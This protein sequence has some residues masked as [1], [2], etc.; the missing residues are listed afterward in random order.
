MTGM[1][2]RRSFNRLILYLLALP[3]IVA[4]TACGGGGTSDEDKPISLTVEHP[5]RSTMKLSWFVRG[6]VLDLNYWFF[7]FV[8]SNDYWVYKDGVFETKNSSS[9]LDAWTKIE[10]LTDSTRYCFDIRLKNSSG[11]L[12]IA[13]QTVC[14]TTQ[15]DNPPSTPQNL[16]ASVISPARINLTWSA[17]T[18]D[19]G[20]RTYGIYR[21]GSFMFTYSIPSVSVSVDPESRHCYQVSAIDRLDK[22]SQLSSEVCAT[23][24]QDLQDPTV[25]TNLYAKYLSDST[26]KYINL[27]WTGSSDD[28]GISYYRVYRN[29]VHIT[30][31]FSP[32]ADHALEIETEYCYHLVAVDVVGHAA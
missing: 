20:V 25:P 7:D 28:G 10:S 17:S 22:E 21:D 26:G 3:L 9:G 30:D 19:Y 24:P 5:S 11:N 6:A 31:E 29:G 13:S 14:A 27:T 1:L 12:E 23:T 18:D 32:Y 15:T 4:V 16:T 2:N 8:K